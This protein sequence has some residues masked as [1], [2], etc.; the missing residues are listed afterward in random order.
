MPRKTIAAVEK[1]ADTLRRERDKALA[2]VRYLL[3]TINKHCYSCSGGVKKEVTYCPLSQVFDKKTLIK[4]C[5]LYPF[6]MGEWPSTVKVTSSD[7]PVPVYRVP[8]TQVPKRVN[9][10]KK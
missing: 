6:R 2:Q 3:R 9:Q 1:E 4:G 5:H 10:V 7:V 8:R